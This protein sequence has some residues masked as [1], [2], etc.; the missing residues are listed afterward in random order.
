MEQLNGE[1][2]LKGGVVLLLFRKLSNFIF[3]LAILSCIPF[4]TDSEILF[5][6]LELA[7]CHPASFFVKLHL[8]YANNFTNRHACLV[9][10]L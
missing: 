10:I 7:I 3:N 1:V 5:K 6:C 8:A 2:T 4:S 9:N